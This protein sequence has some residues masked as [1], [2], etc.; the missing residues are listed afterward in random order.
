MKIIIIPLASLIWFISMIKEYTNAEVMDYNQSEA[1]MIVDH[2]KDFLP[3]LHFLIEHHDEIH[4]LSDWEET[5]I[6]LYVLV[7]AKDKK[8]I[9]GYRKEDGA[10][11]IINYE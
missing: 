11:L 8:Y 2:P 4:Y 6:G 10:I 3:G 1:A 9:I 5:K 7:S